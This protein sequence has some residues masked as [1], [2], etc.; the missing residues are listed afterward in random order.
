MFFYI[1]SLKNINVV[2]LKKFF[3]TFGININA[4]EK[5]VNAKKKIDF[6]I[7]ANDNKKYDIEAQTIS[8]VFEPLDFNKKTEVL[9]YLNEKKK[10]GYNKIEKFRT[11]NAMKKCNYQGFINIQ[12]DS[13]I[14]IILHIFS[15]FLLKSTTSLIFFGDGDVNNYDNKYI[16]LGGDK[17]DLKNK[18]Y[19][20]LKQYQ[21]V[22]IDIK[23]C[24][25]VI[26]HQ[27]PNVICSVIRFF[28]NSP[29][30]VHP[31][32]VDYTTRFRFFVS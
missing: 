8:V 12:M 10:I 18:V 6:F 31:Q 7:D 23:G 28:D 15:L 14:R 24:F 26:A 25:R 32:D 16:I 27:I 5:N 22:D 20:E 19:S 21:K 29:V 11:T 9:N 3:K 2:N 17:S 1:K 4:I 13:K 30:S